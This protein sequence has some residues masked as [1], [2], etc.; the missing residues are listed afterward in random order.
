MSPGPLRQLFPPCRIGKDRAHRVSEMVCGDV[1]DP[2]R[3]SSGKGTA[4]TY[5]RTSMTHGSTT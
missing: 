2:P 1:T 5:L 4:I 3:A